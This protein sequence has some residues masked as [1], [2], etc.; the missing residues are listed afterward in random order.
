[1]HADLAMYEA[2]EAGG[3][4]WRIFGDATG[5]EAVGAEAAR[6]VGSGLPSARRQSGLT[7]TND[8]TIAEQIE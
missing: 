6:R 5:S 7:G 3:G 1:M 2:K 4:G 8:V